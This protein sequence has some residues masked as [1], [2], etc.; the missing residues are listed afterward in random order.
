MELEWEQIEAVQRM[1]DYIGAHLEETITLGALAAVSY[2]SPWYSHRLFEQLTGQTPAGYIRRLRLSRSALE[3]RDG[4]IK[5]L[6]LAL[7][8]GFQSVD[9]YQR[10]FYREFG[11]N[12]REYAKNPVPICLFKPY[13]VKY[14]H[15]KEEKEMKQVKTVFIQVEQRPRRKALIKRGVKAEEYFSYCEEV[16][17]D[18]WGILCSIRSLYGE[19]V[20]MWLPEAM[21]TP[22]TSQY[23]QGV[24]V[25]PDYSGEVP[26]G[27]DV[28]ELPE[29]Q[30]LKFQGE[31][32]AEE[33][34]GAAIGEVWEAVEKFDPSSVGFVWDRDAPRIQL[35]PIGTRGYMELVPVRPIGGPQGVSE[36][37]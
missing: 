4:R 25:A 1:Q 33:D 18:V 30:Y 3:L 34:F 2:Y 10:A 5:I 20:C 37:S 19:P 7:K 27:F 11:C 6:A 13:G 15:P 14:R 35:E 16:G 12:P 32:F 31:P 36:N 21:R 8:T 23:V 22:G 9:G 24:E 26:E 29:G 17:C 28:I